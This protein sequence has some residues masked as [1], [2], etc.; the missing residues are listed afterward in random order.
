MNSMTCTLSAAINHVLHDIPDIF[1]V[2]AI[3]E[4]GFEYGPER[5]TFKI[6]LLVRMLVARRRI[7]NV[8]QLNVPVSVGNVN[9]LL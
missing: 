7:Q 5:S 8:Y 3:T 1:I 9:S 2:Y 6:Y 4:G